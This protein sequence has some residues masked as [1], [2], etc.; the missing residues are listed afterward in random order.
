MLVNNTQK[1]T[2][3]PYYFPYCT[4][5]SLHLRPL[6]SLDLFHFLGLWI[7]FSWW[8]H[9]SHLISPPHPHLSSMYRDVAES[10]K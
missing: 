9:L 1:E 10:L 8:L 5:L 2:P 4:L 3:F 7:P 6:L